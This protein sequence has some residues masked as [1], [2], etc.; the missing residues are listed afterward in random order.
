VPFRGVAPAA[1]QQVLSFN[2]IVNADLHPTS[3]IASVPPVDQAK[4]QPDVGPD[5]AADSTDDIP[6]DPNDY[7]DAIARWLEERKA[8][9][10]L[11]EEQSRKR[12]MAQGKRFDKSKTPNKFK[13]Q[14]AGCSKHS[15]S[16]F[17]NLVPKFVRKFVTEIGSA[18]SFD[19]TG[20]G[21][22]KPQNPNTEPSERQSLPDEQSHC[23]WPQDDEK[24]IPDYVWEY[25]PLVW[26]YSGENYW[27]TTLESH[28]ED[29]E[30][31]F[32][33]DPLPEDEISPTVDHMSYLNSYGT[34]V[35]CTSL[36]DP[37]EYPEWMAGE[38]NIPDDDGYTPAHAFLYA[39]DKGDYLD[40]FWFFFYGFNLGNQVLGIRF[41]NHVGDWEHTA[42]RFKK[43]TGKPIH[44]FYS[45]HEWGSAYLWENAD[46]RNDSKRV[47]FKPQV[48]RH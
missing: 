42:I 41:G 37:E 39:V 28:L 8:A 3:E 29:T 19:L 21:E 45:E 14:D 47:S 10:C 13:T 2:P 23:A 17:G 35:Y 11:S 38:N 12:Q 22:D 32:D 1:A 15:E 40:T 24:S 44:V 26:L 9:G 5:E 43:S 33:Y 18:L 4:I 16:F 27:P 31:F 7:P 6:F 48:E 25:A 20:F 36:D 30:A 34:H 46:R